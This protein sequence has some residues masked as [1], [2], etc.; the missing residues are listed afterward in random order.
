MWNVTEIGSRIEQLRKE[1]GLSRAELANRIGIAPNQLG[2]IERGQHRIL[3]ETIV[4]MGAA[5]DVST[6]FILLGT[7]DAAASIAATI[8][9]MTR[10]QAV[11]ALSLIRRLTNLVFSERGNNALI[12]EALRR[13][14]LQPSIYSY[15]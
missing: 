3:G 4:N 5:L 9:G 12:Q 13:G 7:E 2:K 8:D 1:R 10:T 6:D 14:K 11:L 15:I